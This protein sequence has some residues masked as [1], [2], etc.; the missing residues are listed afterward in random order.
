MCNDI[1]DMNYYKKHFVNKVLYFAFYS[2]NIFTNQKQDSFYSVNIFT[3]QKQD[4][5]SAL[6]SSLVR[7]RP[8]II[9]FRPADPNQTTS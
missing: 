3:D 6:A 8:I 4:S 5:F 9:T 7:D 1:A 2:V